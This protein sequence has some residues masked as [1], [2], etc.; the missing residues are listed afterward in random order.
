MK[1]KWINMKRQWR[2]LRKIDRQTLRLI[3][4]LMLLSIIPIPFGYIGFI[5]NVC[6]LLCSIVLF[7]GSIK[8][9]KVSFAW[10]MEIGKMRSDA[11]NRQEINKILLRNF[12]LDA[13]NSKLKKQLEKSEKQNIRLKNQLKRLRDEQQK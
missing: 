12:K 7:I 11:Q 1:K 8:R 9:S 3:I 13:E 4:V 5:G 2:K 6:W 10:G